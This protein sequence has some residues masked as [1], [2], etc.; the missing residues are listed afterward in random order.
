MKSFDHKNSDDYQ[1]NPYN[2]SKYGTFYNVF[3]IITLVIYSSVTF[4]LN[5]W[6]TDYIDQTILTVIGKLIITFG[7]ILAIS[8]W[9]VYILRQKKIVEIWNK[10]YKLVSY[11]KKC[12][13]YEFVGDHYT[14]MIFFGN[15]FVCISIHAIGLI[16][17]SSYVELLWVVPCTLSS[18]ILIQ[19]AISLNYIYQLYKNINNT[20][21][22]FG[23]IDP[24]IPLTILFGTKIALHE[25]IIVDVANISYIN[26]E[27]YTICNEISNFY[28]IPTLLA[29]IYFVMSTTFNIYF[30]ILS[31]ITTHGITVIL[32]HIDTFLRFSIVAFDF[33]VL[34]TN[35][36]K[37]KREVRLN[38]DC[39]N[40]ILRSKYFHKNFISDQ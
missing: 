36:T 24:D 34:T 5:L 16:I 26:M 23:K 22:K 11:S 14:Y 27:L 2:V 39:I 32:I 8:V 1:S 35:V 17:Y 25:S 29:L 15:C 9:L 40:V 37:L 33:I 30:M 31:I 13:Y 21:I 18:W 38:Y 4:Q 12:H 6:K 3:L 19:Y 20:I 28:A 7:N 10:L